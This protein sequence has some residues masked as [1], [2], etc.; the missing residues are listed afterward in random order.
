MADFSKAAYD[1]QSWENTVIN[2]VSPN[3]SSAKSEII[4][5]GWIPLS[6]NPTF[7][8]DTSPVANQT[9]SNKMSGGYYTNG[10]AA[11]FVARSADA[12]VISFR[13]T[14]DNASQYSPNENPNDPTNAI[15]PDLFD[16]GGPDDNSDRSMTDHYRLLEP[17]VDALDSYVSDSNN[18]VEHVYVTGHSLGGAMAIHF[19]SES[20]HQGAI[21]EA[22]TFAAPAFTEKDMNAQDFGVDNRITQIEIS[23]DPVPDTWLS[24]GRPGQQIEFVGNNTEDTP[25]ADTT[26][27]GLNPSNTDNH[28]MDY[29]RQITQSVDS[30]GWQQILNE[31]GDLS[32]LLGASS[33]PYLTT[34]PI[35][36][37][38]TQLGDQFDT[39]FIVDGWLSG[40]GAYFDNG[41]NILND[42]T[43][44]DFDIFYGGQ[45][46]DKLTGGGAEELFLG[47][48]GNDII[49][50]GGDK[51][52]LF[53]YDGDDQLIGG[54]GVDYLTGGKGADSFIFESNNE[55]EKED[56]ITDFLSGTD[57]IQF[58][59]SEFKDL[60]LGT[61]NT[62]YFV[63]GADP[64]A[65]T[66]SPTFL[67]NT[68]TNMLSFDDNGDSW[69]GINDI[70][71]LQ[72]VPSLRDC[73]KKCV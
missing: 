39:Y 17:L 20:D 42:L 73:K 2:D 63:S 16:W 36:H 40:T 51:D 72:G 25:S 37:N 45:G 22:V 8:T 43:L 31:N 56:I 15:F 64:E 60:A 49:R 57:K 44:S 55:S 50:G 41:D 34:E 59:Q 7:A 9:V 52:R 54:G 4:S 11:A 14:N 69:F 30:K 53:G 18:N 67:F 3:A 68:R 65:S 38:P 70:V 66:G 29:Y 12:V 24:Q 33:G 47:G 26:T 46:N 13:G 23:Q 6:L 1:L 27:G 28:S 35:R 32:V 71:T 48:E 21:Y 62:A 5:Q 10:N 61:L 58:K 19:I